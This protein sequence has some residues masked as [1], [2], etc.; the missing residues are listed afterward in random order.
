[1]FESFPIPDVPQAPKPKYTRVGTYII[2]VDQIHG[3][4]M[5]K[6]DSKDFPY[7]VFITYL[8]KEKGQYTIALEMPSKEAAE[9]ACDKIAEQ[10]G[11][12]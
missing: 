5:S 1:M 6:A 9:K 7:Q 11:A 10:L 12:I 2:T 8:D 4:M 3:V